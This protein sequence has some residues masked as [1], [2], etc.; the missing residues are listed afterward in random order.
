MD[1]NNLVIDHTKCI[2]CG[3]IDFPPIVPCLRMII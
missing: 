2:K 1:D 3:I